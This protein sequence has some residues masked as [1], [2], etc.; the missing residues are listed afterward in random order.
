MEGK[1]EGLSFSFLRM[2]QKH[3][4]ILAD[5]PQKGIASASKNENFVA[6]FLFI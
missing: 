2:G 6:T 4:L 3:V 5:I 1:K